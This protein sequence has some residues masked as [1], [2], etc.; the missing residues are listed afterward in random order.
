MC[1]KILFTPSSLIFCFLKLYVNALTQ[2]TDSF[3]ALD[4]LFNMAAMGHTGALGTEVV[5]RVTDGGLG[6][7][8]CIQ[9]SAP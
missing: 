9:I 2:L 8:V 3:K 6:H 7:G 5:Y 1:K 4:I